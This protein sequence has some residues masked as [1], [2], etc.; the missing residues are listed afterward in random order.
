MKTVKMILI[1]ALGIASGV[2]GYRAW[3]LRNQKLPVVEVREARNG[4]ISPLLDCR[5]VIQ[6]EAREF[7]PLEKKI[8]AVIDGKIQSGAA[9]NVSVF[10]RE[11]DS[12][13]WVGIDENRKYF[14]ASLLKVPLAI[15][16][17]YA[18]ESD[19]SVLSRA[20]RYT[21][22]VNSDLTENIQPSQPLEAGKTYTVDELTERMIVSSENNAFSLLWNGL[23]TDSVKGLFDDIGD[24]FTYVDGLDYVLSPKEYSRFFR[25]LYNATL[26]NHETSN[27]LLGLL[28]RTDFKDGL[29]AG[30]PSGTVVA[31]KFGEHGNVPASSGYPG[32]VEF[33]DCGIVYHPDR[34]Y[35]L[36]VMT[37]GDSLQDLEG[38][39]KDISR[40]VFD[41]VDKNV[42]AQ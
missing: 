35:Q 11:L 34:P 27:K 29:V 31:H 20:Y 10:F 24:P 12:G 38:T 36:C 42:Y 5:T 32:P 30:V 1:L 26:L 19:S 18:A 3:E 21:G 4:L 6:G 16:Y 40:A 41:A 23:G 22:Q 9:K 14:A 8:D 13:R 28:T 25:V 17:Q 33:H 2:L 39:V 7:L 15:A 37:A